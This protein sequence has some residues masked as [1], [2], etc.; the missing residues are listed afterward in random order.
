MLE[1]KQQPFR[2]KFKKGNKIIYGQDHRVLQGV[3]SG[4]WF[5]VF[6]IRD[7]L[8]ELVACGFGCF[9]HHNCYGNGRIFIRIR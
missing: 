7:D 8:W 4:R 5:N 2:V 1:G 6:K 3:P 9:D